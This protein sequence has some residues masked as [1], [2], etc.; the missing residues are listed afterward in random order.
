MENVAVNPGHSR[1]VALIVPQ[2]AL[3]KVGDEPGLECPSNR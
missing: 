2:N 1:L 3:K